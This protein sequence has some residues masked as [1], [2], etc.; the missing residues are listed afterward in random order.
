MNP[1]VSKPLWYSDVAEEEEGTARCCSFVKSRGVDGD[2]DIVAF[3]ET[4]DPGDIVCSG[5]D[6]DISKDTILAPDF[7]Y[8]LIGTSED[9]WEL[10]VVVENAE[11][12]EQKLDADNTTAQTAASFR[13]LLILP[14]LKSGQQLC[15]NER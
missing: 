2:C 6:P 3:D 10:I 1:I 13:K 11:H 4:S 12:G 14:C 7:W 5:T 15:R 8:L 9:L